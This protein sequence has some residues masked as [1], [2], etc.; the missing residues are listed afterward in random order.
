MKTKMRLAIGLLA[1]LM[2]AVLL[3]IQAFASYTIEVDRDCDLKVVYKDNSTPPQ[4]GE[5]LHL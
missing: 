2:A 5:V 3:P 1:I 4:L